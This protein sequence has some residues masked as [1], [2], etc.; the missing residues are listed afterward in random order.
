MKTNR[1]LDPGTGTVSETSDPPMRAD[2]TTRWVPLLGRRCTSGSTLAGPD[3]GGADDGSRTD[4]E[5]LA[6]QR[7]AQHGAVAAHAQRLDPG[8]HRCAVTGGAARDRDHEPGVVDELAVP[9]PHAAAQPVLR[10]R[11]REEHRLGSADRP[12]SA[13]DGIRGSDEPAQ[14]V[15]EPVADPDVCA[16]SHMAR[17]IQRHHLREGTREMRRDARHEQVPFGRTLVRDREL[18]RREVA[19]APVHELRT[20]PAGAVGQVVALDQHRAQ[21]AA[22]GIQRD[23]RTGDAAA[24]HEHVHVGIV[25]QRREFPRAAARR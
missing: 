23:S 3:A 10:D 4:L 11:G 20:P 1:L 15:A 9:A 21:A 2:S 14:A 6:R 22:R 25:S 17:R 19:Q 18:A 8:E 7:V 24:D 5:L 16:A 13:E 12:R